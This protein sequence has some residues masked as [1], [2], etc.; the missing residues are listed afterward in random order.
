M[1]PSIEQIQ[2][3]ENNDRLKI[4][5]PAKTHWVFLSL[6]SIMLLVWVA[7]AIFGIL[8]TA[9]MA[10]SGERF[11][12]VFTVML[13]ALLYLL[14]RLG[15][16]VWGQWQYYAATREILFIHKEMLILRR[17]VSIFGTTTGFDKAHISP[18]YYS[19]KNHCLAF[20]YGHQHV[21]FGHDLSSNSAERL[22]GYL[23]ARYYPN[24]D[25]DDDE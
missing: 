5:L 13:L 20:D 17:P 6:Y 11:A 10:F 21:Y 14:Y 4:V 22:I 2:F 9:Q 8:F 23:N 16:M 19:E 15:K 3:E 25:D 12:F 1:I 24:F 7:M 18:F